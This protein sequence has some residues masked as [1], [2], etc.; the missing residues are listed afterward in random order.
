M[1]RSVVDIREQAQTLVAPLTRQLADYATVKLIDCESEIGS[2]A[3]PDHTLP[4]VAIA[5]RPLASDIEHDQLLQRLASAFRKLPVPV[6]G[7][8]HKGE[9]LLD[10]RCLEDL[11]EFSAQLGGLDP[12][13]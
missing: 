2:G 5:L 9:F 3:L 11:D 1:R 10:C 8:L 6:V 12:G 13:T 7:R 4:S